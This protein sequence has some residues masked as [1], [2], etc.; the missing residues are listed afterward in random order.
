MSIEETQR[1]VRVNLAK[2]R[3]DQELTLE[4]TKKLTGIKT[5]TF[6]HYEAG[7][8]LPTIPNLYKICKGLGVSSNEILGF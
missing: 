2:L 6:S 8:Y 1:Q 4:K 3:H 7:T 5:S